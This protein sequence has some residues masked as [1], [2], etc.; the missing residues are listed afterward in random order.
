MLLHGVHLSSCCSPVSRVTKWWPWIKVQGAHKYH[1]P[2]N[3]VRILD[4]RYQRCSFGH[5]KIAL[6]VSSSSPRC[7]PSSHVHCRA[8]RLAIAVFE[9]TRFST[10]TRTPT[11]IQQ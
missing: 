9:Y 4:S 2:Y 1:C 5:R 3:I 11:I 10:T 7:T 6:H 8:N